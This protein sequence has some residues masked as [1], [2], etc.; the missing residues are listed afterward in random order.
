MG[1]DAH[2]LDMT[3]NGS[4]LDRRDAPD[5]VLVGTLRLRDLSKGPFVLFLGRL[6]RLKGTDDLRVICP[7]LLARYPDVRI[8]ICGVGPDSAAIRAALQ[9]EE[10]AGRVIFLGFVSETVKRWLLE[11]AHVLIAPSFEEG[12]GITVSE[13]IQSGCWVVTYELAAVRES[14]PE[15]PIF[16]PLGDVSTFINQTI[17]C[18]SKPRRSSSGPSGPNS[19]STIAEADLRAILGQ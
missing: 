11:H 6:S 13:G 4:W 12:W 15:G 18:L 2:V 10:K 7:V 8:A 1:L 14:S 9:A 5:D 16:V 17:D 3:R 19:W